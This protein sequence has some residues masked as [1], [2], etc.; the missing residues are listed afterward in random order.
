MVAV[1]AMVPMGGS[2]YECYVVVA[3]AVPLKL[4]YYD[5]FCKKG[6]FK[7]QYLIVVLVNI[8]RSWYYR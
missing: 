2:R 4:S 8:Y 3:V 6:E 7:I 1:L 5:Q